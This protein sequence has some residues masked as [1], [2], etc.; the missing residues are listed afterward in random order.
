MQRIW[1]LPRAKLFSSDYAVLE[2]RHNLSKPSQR[3]R[4]TRL[5]RAVDVVADPPE[6]SLPEGVSLPEKDAPI[7][8]AAIASGATHLLTGDVKHFGRHF[9]QIIEGVLILRPAEYLAS[10]EE[11]S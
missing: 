4:L 9:G 1:K 2:A 11:S 8:A 6:C 3:G 5:L 10:V 7:L